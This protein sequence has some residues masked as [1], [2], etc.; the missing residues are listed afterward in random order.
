MNISLLQVIKEKS[1]S[2]KDFWTVTTKQGLQIFWR[3]ENVSHSLDIIRDVVNFAAVFVCYNG[4]LCGPCISSKHNTILKTVR[5]SDN[6][7]WQETSK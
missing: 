4:V 2:M 3:K 1:K 5:N 6:M 7:P